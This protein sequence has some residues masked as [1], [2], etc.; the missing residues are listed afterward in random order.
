[1]SETIDF[2]HL[3]IGPR[4]R[5]AACAAYVAR[6]I[7]DRMDDQC[8]HVEAR[9]IFGQ[10][11][12]CNVDA[13]RFHYVDEGVGVDAVLIGEPADVA[14]VSFGSCDERDALDLQPVLQRECYGRS[15]C[16]VPDGA[17][18]RTDPAGDRENGL[19]ALKKRR[20][21]AGTFA[22]RRK[23][24]RDDAHAAREQRRDECV[25][26]GVRSFPSVNEKDRR[27]RT[28]APVGDVSG[29][30]PR[31]PRYARSQGFAPI[32]RNRLGCDAFECRVFF[33]RRGRVSSS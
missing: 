19:P 15:A 32:R 10:D 1:M 27:P 25:E 11:E 7:V 22:A 33:D 20:G 6:T 2:E 9:R 16:R 14:F 18:E 26:I 5:D 29:R 21:R 23:I 3:A 12:R 17:G 8:R 28:A 4:R 30:F 13:A 24:E 31:F